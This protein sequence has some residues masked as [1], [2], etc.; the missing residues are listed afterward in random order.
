M[1]SHH[2]PRTIFAPLTGKLNICYQNV[3]AS[4]RKTANMCPIKST[5]HPN[6]TLNNLQKVSRDLL[7]VTLFSIVHKSVL[8]RRTFKA[9]PCSAL[10]KGRNNLPIA[11][12][13]CHSDYLQVTAL[14]SLFFH[15]HFSFLSRSGLY[16]RYNFNNAFFPKNS[17]TDYCN[18][19][20]QQ[21]SEALCGC[22]KNTCDNAYATK[23]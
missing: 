23:N 14:I 15:F 7:C 1:Q 8:R 2:G 10:C 22:C 19:H 16:G 11:Q 3:C 20:H 4:A 5:S 21:N 17:C 12:K 13:S 18:G 9:V 6:W